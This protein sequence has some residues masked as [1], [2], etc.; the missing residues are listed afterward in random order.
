MRAQVER[1]IAR[2]PTAFED[3]RQQVVYELVSALVAPRI[4]PHGLFRRAK[5]LLGEDGIVDV[6][7]LL[8][9]FTAVS[10]TL[11]AFDVPANATGLGQ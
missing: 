4:V 8:R 3:P 1:L 7:V 6:T 11:A 10:L 2:L 9:W 5:H